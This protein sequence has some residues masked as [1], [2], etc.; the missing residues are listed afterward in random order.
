MHDIAGKLRV[1]NPDEKRQ[2]LAILRKRDDCPPKWKNMA[3]KKQKNILEN[4]RKKIAKLL[5][6]EEFAEK[7]ANDRNNARNNKRNMM[8]ILPD[9]CPQTL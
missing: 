3:P 8:D 7:V 4:L 5:N 1:L 2:L 6:P 9:D